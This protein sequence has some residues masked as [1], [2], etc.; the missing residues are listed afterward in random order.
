MLGL[1]DTRY[2]VRIQIFDGNVRKQLYFRRDMT[3]NFMSKW[4]WYFD[5]R[6]ALVK[7]Q[8]PKVKVHFT[9]ERYEYIPPVEVLEKRLKNLVTGKK[10]ALTKYKNKIAK[11]KQVY[12]NTTLF[13]IENDTK[14]GKVQEKL[15]TL[16]HQLKQAESALKKFN[17]GEYKIPENVE[18]CHLLKQ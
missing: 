16:E 2:Y 5:Y 17:A 9:L 4:R 1:R 11:V 15:K 14:W 18:V 13:P 12:Q 6:A 8:N 10:S 3:Y 7:V